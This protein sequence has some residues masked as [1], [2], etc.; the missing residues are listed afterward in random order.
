MTVPNHEGAQQQPDTLPDALERLKRYAQIGDMIAADRASPAAIDWRVFGDHLRS[1]VAALDSAQLVGPASYIDIKTRLMTA[2]AS[3]AGAE[4]WAPIMRELDALVGQQ[5]S[6]GPATPMGSTSSD[7][8]GQQQQPSDPDV[9]EAL[10]IAI[11]WIIDRRPPSADWTIMR[12]RN[13]LADAVWICPD[14]CRTLGRHVLDCRNRE[15]G[16]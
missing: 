12:L 1:A 16:A 10:R 4:V 5:Q 6:F 3:G 14:E 2:V 11:N 8:I 13:V 7:R 9:R 15:E